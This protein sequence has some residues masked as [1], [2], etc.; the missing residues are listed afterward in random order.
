MLRF[1]NIDCEVDAAEVISNCLMLGSSLPV[2]K[3]AQSFCDLVNLCLFFF[4]NKL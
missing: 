4:Y 3:K 2:I 1:V